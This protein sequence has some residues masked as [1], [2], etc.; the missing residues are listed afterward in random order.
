[1]VTC[2]ISKAGFLWLMVRFIWEFMRGQKQGISSSWAYKTRPREEP[3]SAREPYTRGLNSVH[4][5]SC[6]LKFPVSRAS[7]NAKFRKGRVEWGASPPLQGPGTTVLELLHLQNAV[8][9]LRGYFSR[10]NGVHTGASLPLSPCEQGRRSLRQTL[11]KLSVFPL[12]LKELVCDC[13]QEQ[14]KVRECVWNWLFLT[15]QGE[16][17][18]LLGG[19]LCN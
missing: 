1:M 8:E 19:E 4:Y 15:I 2:H 13:W 6:F 18:K 12:E 11:R 9:E 3:F 5:G 17:R 7:Q 16:R 10:A 14:F